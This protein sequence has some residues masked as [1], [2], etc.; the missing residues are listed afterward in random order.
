M[1]IYRVV[2][3]HAY[4]GHKPGTRFEASIPPDAEHRALA[5]GDIQVIDYTPVGLLPGSYTLPQG[6][7]AAQKREE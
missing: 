2:G 3:K 5:R 4:R 6:W 1:S 7:L